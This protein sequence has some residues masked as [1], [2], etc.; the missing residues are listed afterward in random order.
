MAKPNK[1]QKSGK[2]TQVTARHRMTTEKII[3]VKTWLERMQI[4][5]AKAIS[6]AE[7]MSP[8]DMNESNDL[9]W[10]LA[11]YTE[12][13]Q[14]SV[15]QLDGINKRIY[16]ALIELDEHAWQGLKGMRSRLAHTFWNI[17]AQ[18]LRSTIVTDFPTLLALLSTIIVIDHPVGDN[19]KVSFRFKTDRLLGLPDLT[20][21]SVV[22]AGRSIVALFFGY[23][24]KV[25]VFRVGHDGSNRL[26]INTNFDTQFSVYGRR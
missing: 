2:Q 10:A 3:E 25:G 18:I 6:L 16:P 15:V 7:R 23:N 17:N 14:E 20:S 12:N 4:N 24:G 8:D 9:F 22:E 11:K 21:A 26:V 1:K 13:V 5:A 19:E